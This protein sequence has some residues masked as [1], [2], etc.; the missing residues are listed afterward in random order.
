MTFGRS[1]DENSEVMLHETKQFVTKKTYRCLFSDERFR[2]KD[3]FDRHEIHYK[4]EV[5]LNFHFVNYVFKYFLNL[6]EKV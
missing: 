6:T 2:N 3:T 1:S 5:F 4:N